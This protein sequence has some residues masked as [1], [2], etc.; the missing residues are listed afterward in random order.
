MNK[1]HVNNTNL[2]KRCVITSTMNIKA[3]NIGAYNKKIN[4]VLSADES[5]K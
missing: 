3:L 1:A 5:F 4:Q 2:L